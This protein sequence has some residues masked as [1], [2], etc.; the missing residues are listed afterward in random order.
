VHEKDP[1]PKFFVKA[2]FLC[3]FGICCVFHGVVCGYSLAMSFTRA[4][5]KRLF[6]HMWVRA[7][8]AGL[9]DVA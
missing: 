4:L 9:D 5:L 1:E 3:G 7:E 6:I 2:Y 8:E